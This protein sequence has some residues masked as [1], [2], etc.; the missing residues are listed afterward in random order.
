MARYM[1]WPLILILFACS[2]FILEAACIAEENSDP[3]EMSQIQESDSAS[4]AEQDIEPD[5]PPP[6]THVIGMITDD[7]PAIS[8]ITNYAT[9][10]ELIAMISE[11]AMQQFTGFF[12]PSLIQVEPFPY[13]WE[14]EHRRPS[15]LGITLAD[16]MAA[17]LNNYTLGARSNRDQYQSAHSNTNETMQWV[18]GT[19]QEMDGFLRIHISARNAKGARRSYV[20]NAQMSEPIYRALHTVPYRSRLH[21]NNIRYKGYSA[22]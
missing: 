13:L 20:V 21:A 12:E 2:F 16:Q 7:A 3:E 18:Q 5:W 17:M 10:T 22:Q 19:M 6:D 14:Y 15:M 11:D 9:L 4:E 8:S 1:S